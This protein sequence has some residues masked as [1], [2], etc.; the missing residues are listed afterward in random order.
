MKC[1]EEIPNE[2]LAREYALHRQIVNAMI[3]NNGKNNFLYE[4]GGLNFGCRKQ[5]IIDE[6]GGGVHCIPAHNDVDEPDMIRVENDGKL[7]HQRPNISTYSVGT[8]LNEQQR[9]C[10]I[11]GISL[12]FMSEE[13]EA[14]WEEVWDEL[15]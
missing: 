15:Y 7:K 2:V 3:V 12:G 10:L 1:W 14:R 5:F 11:S 4:K 13:A 6:D 8:Y 9:N